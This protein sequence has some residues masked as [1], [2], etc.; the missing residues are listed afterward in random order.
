MFWP[1]K[2][3]PGKASNEPFILSWQKV[4]YGDVFNEWLNVFP[5]YCD[6]TKMDEK[7]IN[8]YKQYLQW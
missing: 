2:I 1:H 8:N 4:R 7:V 3:N 6:F 5:Q